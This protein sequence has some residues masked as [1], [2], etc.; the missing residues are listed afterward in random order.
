[1]QGFFVKNI[2]YWTN[3]MVGI[4]RQAFESLGPDEERFA[5]STT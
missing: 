5:I 2:F 1:M 4:G 3:G